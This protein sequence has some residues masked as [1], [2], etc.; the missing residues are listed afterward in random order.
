MSSCDCSQ[1][2]QD[3]K[4]WFFTALFLAVVLVV[5]I[6]NIDEFLSDPSREIKHGQEMRRL[7][8]E[9]THLPTG[10]SDERQL[11]LSAQTNSN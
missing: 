11:S 8:M 10:V 3:A 1:E 6:F 4:K 9:A 5:S 7:R 2:A